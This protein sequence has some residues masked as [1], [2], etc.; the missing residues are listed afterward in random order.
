MTELLESK[1]MNEMIS[2]RFQKDRVYRL[3]DATYGKHEWAVELTAET[4][5]V[6]HATKRRHDW[7]ERHKHP[8]FYNKGDKNL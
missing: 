5:R 6:I 4:D 3:P 7:Q 2:I 8:T 1:M